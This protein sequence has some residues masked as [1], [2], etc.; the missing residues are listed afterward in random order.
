MPLSDDANVI[1][2][3]PGVPYYVWHNGAS[4]VWDNPFLAG[5]PFEITYFAVR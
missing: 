2:I 3:F 1:A 4:K 5:E